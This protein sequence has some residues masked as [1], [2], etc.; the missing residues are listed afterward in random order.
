MTAAVIL[1][2]TD[3]SQK[4]IRSSEIPREQP[5]QILEKKNIWDE[6]PRHM[7]HVC[8]KQDYISPGAPATN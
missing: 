3:S 4:L 5:C 2:L 1:S 7:G 6:L 8:E